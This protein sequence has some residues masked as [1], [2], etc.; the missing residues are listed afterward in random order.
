M[1]PKK[2]TLS[3]EI[4][5]RMKNTSQRVCNTIRCE[6]L[7]DFMEKLQRSGYPEEFRKNCLVAAMKGYTRMV[8]N[9]EEGLGP[10]NRQRGTRPNRQKKRLGKLREKGSWYKRPTEVY[11]FTF[12]ASSKQKEE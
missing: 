4:I 10:V 7:T 6:I 5:R 8:K 3:Q 9:E 12:K 1:S 11:L 2:S